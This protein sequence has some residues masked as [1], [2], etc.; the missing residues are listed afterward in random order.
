MRVSSADPS[1]K[2]HTLRRRYTR[3]PGWKLTRFEQSS[4]KDPYGTELLLPALY[5]FERAQSTYSRLYTTA[6]N[7]SLIF[8]S[9]IA[10]VF[11]TRRAVTEQE[12]YGDWI[13]LGQ[14]T[15]PPIS[16]TVRLLG[17]LFFYS[18]AINTYHVPLSLELYIHRTTIISAY[19]QYLQ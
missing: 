17:L 14:S 11:A 4:L 1:R 6:V 19:D 10:L 3:S 9:F 16:V 8:S 13:S 18:H 7:P 12:H 2:G 5:K 15:F